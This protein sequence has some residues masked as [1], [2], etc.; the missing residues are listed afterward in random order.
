MK[1]VLIKIT[2]ID[3]ETQKE[4]SSSKKTPYHPGDV[5]QVNFS[6]IDRV[7]QVLFYA[8]EAFREIAEVIE[9][10]EKR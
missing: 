2:V 9:S 1:T 4:L 10:E 8:Q 5:N 3:D 7:N 6:R